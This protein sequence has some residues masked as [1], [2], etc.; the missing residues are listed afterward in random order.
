MQP[1]LEARASEEQREALF[2]IL[3]AADQPVGTMFQIFS[4]IIEHHHDPIFT[5]IGWEWDIKKRRAA[6]TCRRSCA[7]KASRSE[8]R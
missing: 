7:P 2:Y 3:T 8:T 6:S 4:V 5:E 1:I